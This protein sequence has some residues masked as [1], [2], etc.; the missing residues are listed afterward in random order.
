M[1]TPT[2]NR[3]KIP[4]ESKVDSELKSPGNVKKR[5]NETAL[6][7]AARNSRNSTTGIT[8]TIAITNTI[9]MLIA[10]PMQPTT[11]TSQSGDPFANYLNRTTTYVCSLACVFLRFSFPINN[12]KPI[13]ATATGIITKETVVIAT[14]IHSRAA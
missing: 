12:D 14:P 5:G 1:S 7:T 13:H 8:Q 3:S 6:T 4:S 2:S 9:A 11:P 10:T